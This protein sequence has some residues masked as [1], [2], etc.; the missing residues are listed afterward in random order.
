MTQLIFDFETLSVSRHNCVVVNLATLVFDE[1]RFKTDPYTFSELVNQ[2]TL[3]KFD[4]KE[5]QTTYNRTI[6]KDTLTWWQTLPKDIQR[7]LLPSDKDVSIRTIPEHIPNPDQ[8]NTVWSRGNTFDPIILDYLMDDINH[9]HLFK[10]YLV[11]DTRS[12]LDGLLFNTGIKNN[13]MPDNLDIPFKHHDPQHDVALD[14]IRM[15]TVIKHLP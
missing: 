3:I 6:D 2:S 1:T 14:V 12:Y 15:Q 13:F 8:H 5:Q 4:I 11:K 7:Q 9:P 10:F